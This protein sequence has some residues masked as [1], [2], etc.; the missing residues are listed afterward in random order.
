MHMGNQVEEIHHTVHVKIPNQMEE[1]QTTQTKIVN[2][3]EELQIIHVK[4][5]CLYLFVCLI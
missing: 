5:Y 2:E 1:I 4:K 3:I